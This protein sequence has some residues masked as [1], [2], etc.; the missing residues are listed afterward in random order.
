[1]AKAKTPAENK[2]AAEEK[3]E[4]KR[5]ALLAKQNDQAQGAD[6][7]SD[8]DV[9]SGSDGDADSGTDGDAD[10]GAGDDA[11]SGAGDDA[12]SGT[13]GDADSGTDGDVDSGT[14]GDAGSGTEGDADSGADDGA[15]QDEHPVF[16][17]D[18]KLDKPK[19]FK[20]IA[21]NTVGKHAPGTAFEV[22]TPEQCER[23]LGLGAAKK[24]P[25]KG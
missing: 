1:M 14:D 16:Y 9:G 13:D 20:L 11:D 15:E 7:G 19:R 8:G 25:E 12:D 24:A 18:V 4:K 22:E 21:I 6:S 10:S 23:L 2:A 17:T 5:L 3:A